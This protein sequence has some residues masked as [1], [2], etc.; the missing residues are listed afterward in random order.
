MDVVLVNFEVWS[1]DLFKL[2][3]DG[4]KLYGRGMMDC[5]GYVALMTTI[6]A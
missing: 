4:D 2:M 5:L 1:V 6:F 3:M